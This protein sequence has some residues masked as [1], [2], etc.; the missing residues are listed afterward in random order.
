VRID[1]TFG[2]RFSMFGRYNEAPSQ[3]AVRNNSLSEIDTTDVGTRT[4]TLGTTMALSPTI[5]NAL[6]GN[7]S[8][9]TSGQVTHLDSFGGAVP[10]S[11]NLLAPNVLNAGNLN[12]QFYIFGT[13]APYFTG[14]KAQNRS[15][16]LNFADDFAVSHALHQFKFGADYRAIYMNLAPASILS[17]FACSA[18]TFVSKGQA[19]CGIQGISA[20]PSKFLFQSTSLYAQDSWKI[21]PRLTV[22]YGLRWELD[23]AP[24][25]RGATVIS[26]WRNVSNPAGLSLAP[27]GSPLWNTTYTNFA[28]RAG[29]AYSL[30]PNGNFVLR[31]G[32]GFFYD[33]GTDAVGYLGSTFPNSASNFNSTPAS[34]PLPDARP[35]LPTIS[36]QPPFP[37]GTS[38]YA[39]NLKLPRSYQ[40]NVALEKSFAGQQALSLTYVGQAGRDLLRQEGISQP[41]NN[42]SGS[43]ILTQNNARSNYNA[44]QLQ[45]RRPLSQRVQALLNY[46]WSHS[47]DNASDDTIIAKAI[48]SSVLSAARDYASSSFDVRNS[49]SGAISYMIPAASMHGPLSVL[50]KDWSVQALVVARGGF[51][52]NGQILTATIAGAFPRPDLDPTQPVWLYG[53]QYPGG[54]AL[55]AAE[56]TKPPAGQQGTEGR[57]DIRGFGLTEVDLSLGR[58]LTMTER[59]N[60]QFRVDAFNL[61]NHPNFANPFAYIG[62]GPS[63]LQSMS[64][65]NK[66]L[67]GLNPVFQEGGPRSLQISLKVVF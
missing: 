45:Y 15:T 67:G 34:L 48:S 39:P 44:L 33:L 32:A 14:P 27:S 38:G 31:V 64:M 36:V 63:F 60:V 7:Y 47:L 61:L 65:L 20:N 24:S 4:L 8:L 46:T 30:T 11:L 43:F 35:Y 53:S 28:P 62:F 6:R 29:L 50:S 49:F 22:T 1:H 59:L 66:G 57:N 56:F 54:K 23:P 9:Q 58:K 3:T 13:S 16:Q 26:A 37:N 12:V 19:D 2:S 5:A 55:N 40:W 21:K 25:T 51:P 42:F 17:Y 18:Q 52:F 41:N 10:P